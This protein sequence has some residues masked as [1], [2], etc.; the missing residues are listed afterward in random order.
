MRFSQRVLFC[1]TQHA[2]FVKP[3]AGNLFFGVK[4]FAGEVTY[5][6]AGFLQKNADKPPEDFIKLIPSSTQELLK[7]LGKDSEAKGR[8]YCTS[9]GGDWPARAKACSG[10]FDYT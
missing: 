3:K 7:Q 10:Q 4:H 1:H 8:V 6:C 9:F 5:N 2:C